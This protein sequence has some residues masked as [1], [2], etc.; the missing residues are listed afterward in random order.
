MS[1]EKIGFIG[2]G[3][4]GFAMCYGMYKSGYSMV[5]PTYRREIDQSGSFIPMAPDQAA[6]TA[7]Y[8]EML[9]NGCEG[10]ESS[11]ELFQ[12]SDY[13]L[14][15]MPTS[16]QVEMNMYGEE[17]ILANAR[18]GTVIIDLTSADASSTKKLAKEC[19][20]KGLELLDAPISGGQ[21]GAANQTLTIM[22]GGEKEVFEKC[23]P[24]FETLG[25][26][27]KVTYAGPSGA[28]DALK[29]INNYLSCTCLLATTEALSAAVKAG[30]DPHVAAQVIG[31]GGGS[32]NASTYKFPKLIFTGQG[33]NMAVDL[34]KKDIGLFNGLAK[35]HH[36]PNFYGNLSYQLFDMQTGMG[37]GG[38]DFSCVVRQFEE[39][40]GVKLFDI[41]EKEK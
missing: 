30:I 7:L 41:D 36:I 32:S 39:W 13:I 3:T 11:A 15:S 5:L 14:I 9:N 16:R 34:M 22:V 31:N 8:D 28:G 38:E 37:K 4:M 19:K 27:E 17:G 33:M 21:A 29:C 35:E 10:A 1:K 25:A 40:T 6:K 18:P 24:I 23:L 2:L 12:K 20:E 26:P